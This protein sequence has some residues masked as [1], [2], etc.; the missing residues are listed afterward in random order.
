MFGDITK[1]RANILANIL[2]CRDVNVPNKSYPPNPV[3]MIIPAMH[4][5]G[6]EKKLAPIEL[7]GVCT[8]S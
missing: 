3:L 8:E 5:K 6:E 2:S 4:K 7:P 1:F